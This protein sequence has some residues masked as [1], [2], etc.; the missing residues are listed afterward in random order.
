MGV[1]NPLPRGPTTT[2][3]RERRYESVTKD[4]FR[5]TRDRGLSLP[6]GDP[7]VSGTGVVTNGLVS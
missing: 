5:G 3:G 1:T 7:S 2:T 6:G 4:T